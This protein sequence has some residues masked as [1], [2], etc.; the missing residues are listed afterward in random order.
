V[1]C[2]WGVEAGST[3]LHEAY[4]MAMPHVD[5]IRGTIC[6]QKIMGFHD[7]CYTPFINLGRSSMAGHMSGPLPKGRTKILLTNGPTI[8]QWTGIQK[9]LEH[10][11]VAKIARPDARLP[12]FPPAYKTANFSRHPNTKKKLNKI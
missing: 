2:R 3:A 9:D 1:G 4:V 8:W 10:A 6:D 7:K 12:A 11:S 5:V